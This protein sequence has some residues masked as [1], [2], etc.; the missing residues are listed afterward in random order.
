MGTDIVV[1]AQSL[2]VTYQGYYLRPINQLLNAETFGGFKLVVGPTGIGKTYAIP[3]TI[4]SLRQRADFDKRCIYA[5]HRHILLEEMKRDLDKLEIPS[6]YLKRNRH[7]VCEFVS[8]PGVSTFLAELDAM[9]FFG[10]KRLS[11]VDSLVQSIGRTRRD[12]GQKD[13]SRE[14]KDNL[15]KELD[16]KCAKLIHLFE[17]GL[18]MA[19]P[20]TYDHLVQQKMIWQLFPYIEFLYSPTRPVLLVTTDKLLRGFFDG[21]RQQRITSLRDNV[22]FFDEFEIQEGAILKYLCEGDGIRNNF[23]FVSLFYNEMASER[24]SGD[25][26]PGSGVEERDDARQRIVKILERIEQECEAGGYRFPAIARFTLS[27]SENKPKK[28]KKKGEEAGESRLMVFQSNHIVQTY[29]FYLL[30]EGRAWRITRQH[31]EHTL[32]SGRLLYLMARIA[33]EILEFFAS[34]WANGQ[35]DEWHE[36]IALCYN[37]RNDN[38]RGAYHD[39]IA[40]YGMLRRPMRFLKLRNPDQIR[41]SIYYKGFSQYVL[42][43]G[44]YSATLPDEVDMHQN[45]MHITPEYL[46]WQLCQANLLFGISATGDLPRYVKTFDLKWL[47]DNCNYIPIDDQDKALIAEMKAQKEQTRNYDV[48]FDL[49]GLLPYSHP[50]NNFLDRLTTEGVFGEQGQIA[51]TARRTV[52]NR[53]LET[54]R[55][56][57]QHSHN[58]AHL[59]FANSIN[60]ILLLLEQKRSM[61]ELGY[62]D[63][64][65]YLEVRRPSSDE[66]SERMMQEYRLTF[67]GQPVYVILLNAEKARKR[68]LATFQYDSRFG[69]LVV[70]TQYETA[71]NGVNLEWTDETKRRYDFQGIHLLEGKH[72]YFEQQQDETDSK[73]PVDTDKMF[74]WQAWKL[75]EGRQISQRQLRTY[76][77]NWQNTGFNA[78]S[79]F[80]SAVY[81]KTP[82]YLLNQVALFDQAFGRV[83][84]KPNSTHTTEV[85]LAHTSSADNSEDGVFQLLARYV[86]EEGAIGQLRD[87][88]APYTSTLILKIHEAIRARSQSQRLSNQFFREDISGKQARSRARIEELLNLIERMKSGAFSDEQARSIKRLWL[89]VR[90]AVLSQDYQYYGEFEGIQI[91]F[92]QDFVHSTGYLQPYDKLYL[93]RGQTAIFKEASIDTLDFSLNWPYRRLA[94]NDVIRRFFEIRNYQLRHYHTTP[95]Y[96]FVPHVIQAI[97]AGAV[98]EAALEALLEQA[99][100][101]LEVPYTHDPALFEDFDLK[102][103]G[104]PIY[105]DAKSFSRATIYRMNAGPTDPDYNPYLNGP[106]LLEK[107]LAKWQRIVARTGQKDAKFVIINLQVDGWRLNEYWDEQLKPVKTFHESAITIIQGALDPAS[108]NTLRPQFQLWLTD[109]QN[110]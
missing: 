97:L 26:A 69:P 74:V 62:D 95:N 13:L 46:I 77:G 35:E 87:D 39:I 7:L 107:A 22:I 72:F 6:V 73:R 28:K 5:A 63:L 12:M 41:N 27:E 70:V 43:R 104:K 98:G 100:I 18:R 31:S 78:I 32:S 51:I 76:M 84:R 75:A 86:N 66:P 89:D 55:W 94:E 25:L 53:F 16:R 92:Q 38:L 88:R 71:A 15:G 61:S 50:L 4:H 108:P 90:E 54:L 102:I 42:T 91:G 3:W 47:Q 110:F 44:R 56:I 49:A 9:K 33:D 10:D 17:Y 11:E 101:E 60:Y 20:T 1:A 79:V 81:K 8:E 93:D 23:E 34:L 37:K 68:R 109:V 57:V 19:G 65:Q 106:L 67:E 64:A 21:Q 82:D 59:V 58:Q 29:P 103:K 14:T 48:R 30:D 85:R 24:E 45:T 36:W 40:R 2:T 96:I 80:N 83:D 52:V 99:E 105:L